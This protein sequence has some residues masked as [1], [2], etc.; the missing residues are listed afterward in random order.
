MKTLALWRDA[1]IQARNDGVPSRPASPSS[2]SELPGEQKQPS[3]GALSPDDRDHKRSN[4]EPLEPRVPSRKST[5]SAW[6]RWWR[7][8]KAK[9]A[10]TGLKRPGF[11]GST[12][13]S[14]PV[15]AAL[16][17]LS[18]AL[19]PLNGF[20]SLQ[21]LRAWIRHRRNHHN[22]RY[23]LTV[24]RLPHQLQ[25]PSRKQRRNNLR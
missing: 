8:G 7:R 15:R 2:D 22:L 11:E 19:M 3:D 5:S 23:E 10:E 14:S 13:V 18:K 17:R 1:A 9:D 12:S 6:T 24:R 21:L 4:S 20:R 16:L 25:Y